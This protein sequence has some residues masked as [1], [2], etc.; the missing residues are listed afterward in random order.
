MSHRVIS[1]LD[2]L[3]K[4]D[5]KERP[6][7]V[8]TFICDPRFL[9]KITSKGRTIYNVWKK[10]LN[11]VL[12]EDSK[13]MIVFTG[14]IGTGKTN[15]AVIGICFVMHRILCLKNP[16]GFF[17]LSD[18]DKMA[19]A[20]FNLTRDLGKSKDFNLLQAFLL[21]SSWFK[22]RAINITGTVYPI[23]NFS[24]FKYILSSPYSKG[25]GV[26]GEHVIAA[27]M[28][29]VDSPTESIKQKERVLKAY[30]TTS[31][32]FES[33]FVVDDES[34]GRFFLVASK[35]DEVA[36]LN[37]FVEEMKG[38]KNVYVVDVPLGGEAEDKL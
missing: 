1:Y 37:T 30:K 6:V 20:F 17:N 31:R 18:G 14:A 10:E 29:E 22:E 11:I 9:G 24:I 16:W 2:S 38:A 25:F 27:I 13:T 3:Y 4:M 32:R 7:D 21:S 8:E 15:S 36:F 12:N 19:I 28:D 26:I 35:Q 34:I 5:Y 33:R 23:V